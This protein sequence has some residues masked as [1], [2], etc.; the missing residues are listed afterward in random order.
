MIILEI[1]DIVTG[2]EYKNFKIKTPCI[3][4]VSTMVGI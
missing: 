3:I 1:I 2:D 4:L